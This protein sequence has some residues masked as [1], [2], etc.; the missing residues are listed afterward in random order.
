MFFWISV[1]FG[2]LFRQR[3]VTM[4]T[5]RKPGACD[6]HVIGGSPVSGA[7]TKASGKRGEPTIT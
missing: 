3:S 4:P 5:T 1:L 2:L 7:N 6:L